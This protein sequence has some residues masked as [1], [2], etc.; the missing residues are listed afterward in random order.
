MRINIEFSSD[1]LVERAEVKRFYRAVAGSLLHI[2]G[3]L[4]ENDEVPTGTTAAE[5]RQS[6][7]RALPEAYA[8]GE[9]V[10]SNH[11]TVPPAPPLNG[12]TFA[13]ASAVPPP[14]PPPAP[15][16]SNVV[17]FPVPPPPPPPPVNTA[18][19]P[20]PPP[21]VPTVADAPSAVVSATEATAEYDS[22]GM[23]WDARIHQKGKNKK[24]DGTWKLQK[25]INEKQ[26]GLVEAV[27]KE[28]AARKNATVSLP[29]TSSVPV[30]P[31]P[32]PTAVAPVPVPPPPAPVSVSGDSTGG[33]VPP[34]PGGGF[35]QL[36]DNILASKLPAENVASLCQFHGA[37][38]LQELNKMPHLWP[39]FQ[40]SLG[41]IAAGIPL[42]MILAKMA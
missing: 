4:D 23:A 26:P 18:V 28:L 42:E 32:P 38:N 7:D 34:P 16:V 41:K 8:D 31:P 20:P 33:A 10:A 1:D 6:F 5:P 17:N 14:P 12:Y 39:E 19:P 3:D 13:E 22:A 2:I 35:K 11:G 9:P 21:P 40:G 37:Q 25:G 30:P 29:A 24:A 27:V 36:I 15:E